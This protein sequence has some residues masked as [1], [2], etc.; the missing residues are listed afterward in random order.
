MAAIWMDDLYRYTGK[1]SKIVFLKE[2]IKNHE[3]R[4]VF[5]MRIC[6]TKI[7]F[8]FQ[9]F[10]R[11]SSRRHGIDLSPKTQIAAGFYVG[12]A[13]GITVNSHA[14]LGK[15]INIHKGATIGRTNRGKY[16]GTPV[17]GNN[18]FIGINATVVGAIV[19][20]DDVM[21]APNSYVSRDVPSHSVVIGNPA[22]IIPN[23]HATADYV[24]RAV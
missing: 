11:W 18:V 8:C 17:I 9:I 21:I 16:K 13:W 24:N 6:N 7:G 15:N 20:G 2:I 10:Y 12:H 4:F 1:R 23:A 22:Q 14:V 3:Y 19:I 5:L